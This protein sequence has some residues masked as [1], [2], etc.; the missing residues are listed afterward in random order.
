MPI[1]LTGEDRPSL[2][3]GWIDALPVPAARIRPR[4][5]GNFSLHASN[6]A[7]DRLELAPADARAPIE[8]RRAIE[9]AARQQGEA[10]EFSCRLGE[11]PAARDLRGSIGP[12]TDENGDNSLFLLTLIDRTQEMM[13]ERN[14]RRELV[15]DSLTG[16]PNRAGFEELGATRA[17]GEATAEQATVL[18]ALAR[19][20]RLTE[21]IGPLAGHDLIITFG[22]RPQPSRRG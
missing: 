14:L 19:F 20:R 10:Q 1:D 21:H 3:V 5:R 4:A 12:L 9:R 7:F 11:G 17:E 8:M 15:S 13:I 16:L 6:G 18:L 22:R 2:Y